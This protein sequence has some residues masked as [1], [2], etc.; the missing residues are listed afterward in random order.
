MPISQLGPSPHCYSAPLRFSALS[1]SFDLLSEAWILADDRSVQFDEVRTFMTRLQA[2]PVHHS[3]ETIC[4]DLRA[5]Q[6]CLR[7]RKPKQEV[8]A[9]HMPLLQQISQLLPPRPVCQTLVSMYVENFEHELRVLHV[10]T[11]LTDLESVWNPQG[12]LSSPQNDV[13][14]QLVLVLAIASSVDPHE[15]LKGEKPDGQPLDAI[16]CDLAEAWI[17][18]LTPKKRLRFSALQTQTLLLMATQCRI[19]KK[20]MWTSTG[21]LVR[22]AML[23]G[24]HR[25]PSETTRI[26]PFQSELRRRLWYTIVEM[27]LQ[28]S[29][30][31]G[32]PT[33]VCTTDFTTRCPASIDDVDLHPDLIDLPESQSLEQWTD[34]LPHALLAQWLPDRLTGA[35]LLSNM[36]RGINYEEAL[37][38][39]RNLDEKLRD[40]P[41]PL[42]FDHNLDD[43]NHKVSRVQARIQFDLHIR[44]SILNLCGPFVQANSAV[45]HFTEAR[46][47]FI[48]SATTISCY[49]DVFDPEF[50]DFTINTIKNW[51]LF[52]VCAKHDLMHA[53]LGICLEI[54]RSSVG[55][56]NK[57]GVNGLVSAST[58]TTSTY[59]RT[60]LI[61]TVDDNLNPLI[62]RLG[63]FGSDFKDLMCLSV[64]LSSVRTRNA[65]AKQEAIE[66]AIKETIDSSKRHLEKLGLFHASYG[67]TTHHTPTSQSTSQDMSLDFGFGLDAF[68]DEQFDFGAI[69]FN[70]ANR[71]QY[72]QAAV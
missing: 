64:V 26:S 33:M 71:W 16:Y 30:T 36:I 29:L 27:D 35:R 62:R 47:L 34:S 12:A 6:D 32:M 40:L 53:G 58:P 66:D 68:M 50:S 38:H 51:D 11:L 44:R 65:E 18:E 31:Q 24:L 21:S 17:D 42:K 8:V 1:G 41:S 13:L 69:D 9:S 49:Q 22:S 46:R 19:E 57:G 48:Q 55:A 25:D 7:T 39:A 61:K 20:N 43:D 28:T 60:S 72:G 4:N 23:A 63:R 67:S 70:Y 54:K 3:L 56:L 59:S 45:S 10:P 37:G 2:T 5:V 15:L 14:P 52:H